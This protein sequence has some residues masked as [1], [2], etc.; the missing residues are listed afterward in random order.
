MLNPNE[1]N[2]LKW[3]R[4]TELETMIS[5][6][7][8][9]FIKSQSDQKMILNALK[10]IGEFSGASR[11]YIF[12]FQDNGIWM[13]NTY[14]W[15]QSG[16][17]PQIDILKNQEIKVFPWWMNK[18]STGKP[19][20]INDVSKLP[21]EAQAEKDILAMQGILSVLVMPIMKKGY[22]NGFIG[23]DNV[24]T[25]GDWQEE[26]QSALQFASELFSH[27]FDRL[28][29]ETELQETKDE[30]E[31]T[32]EHVNSIQLKLIQ[33]EQMVG[34]GHLASGVAH[35]INNPLG[36]I[37]S[38]HATLKSYA[39]DL[40]QYVH[41]IEERECNCQLS[42]KEKEN[43]HFIEEDLEDLFKDIDEGL[44]RVKTI[45]ESLRFF[46]FID[47]IHAFN[48]YDIQEGL[49]NTLVL[50][51]TRI[52]ESVDLKLYID[53][54]LPSVYVDGS[55]MNQVFL[56]LMTNALDAI[57]E[58]GSLKTGL[59]EIKVKIENG[60]MVIQFRDNGKGMSPEEK[61]HIFTPFFTTKEA[62]R[63]TGLGMSF[64]YD[65]VCNVHK[66]KIHV[67]SEKGVGTTIC[68]EIPISSC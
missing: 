43:V 68:V 22:L 39:K 1:L 14:E 3:Q 9:D 19:L 44:N 21:K 46:S 18:L 8:R 26:D 48:Y 32:L 4:K 67:E 65:T 64:V 56:N 62:G 31:Q 49:K 38:N 2:H 24:E 57:D 66:G 36:F 12:E 20:I 11:A 58:A 37:L 15:C 35:E 5:S 60:Y 16:V 28:E 51:Q 7:A 61:A 54:N 63:G 55:K 45:V 42:V 13:D 10:R 41:K 30:L 29:W 50:I 17:S 6:I 34:I 52:K 33:Q 40:L 47:S 23:F 25:K 59:I 27:F 53:S